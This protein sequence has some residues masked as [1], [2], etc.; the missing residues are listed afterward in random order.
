[1]TAP[2]R[3][4]CT[5]SGRSSAPTRLGGRSRNSSVWPGVSKLDVPAANLSALLV[6]HDQGGGVAGLVKNLIFAAN[7]PKPELVLRDAVSNDIEIVKN[8]YCLVF[9]QPIPADGLTFKHLI[10]WWRVHQQLPDADDRTVGLSLHARLTSSMNGNP[11]ECVVF[12]A[13]SR[14]YR[15]HGFDVPALILR[16]TFITT[17]TR[18]GLAGRETGRSSGS[19]WTSCY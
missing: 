18:P 14:R 7:G 15:E 9:D 10:D 11:A 2:R 12:D 3:A 1:M 4:S 5:P 16:F 8:E 6:E 13:Y 19:G 17:R